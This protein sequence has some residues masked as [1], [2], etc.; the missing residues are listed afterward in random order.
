MT[1]PTRRPTAPAE[2]KP[3]FD[4]L[5]PSILIELPSSLVSALDARATVRGEAV[6]ERIASILHRSLAE[7]RSQT[8]TDVAEPVILDVEQLLCNGELGR[9]GA[10]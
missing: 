7:P 10:G 4:S 1:N 5:V 9:S 2:P 3:L 8:G 6:E